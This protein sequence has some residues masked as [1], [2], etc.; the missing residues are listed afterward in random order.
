MS[1]SFIVLLEM[2]KWSPETA[3][4]TEQNRKAK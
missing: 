4:K 2:K 3:I 1:E